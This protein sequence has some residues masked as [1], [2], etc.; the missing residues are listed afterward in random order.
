MNDSFFL[1]WNMI[2]LFLF[3]Q[4]IKRSFQYEGINLT[5]QRFLENML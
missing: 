1:F 4:S 5:F 2:E 3:K